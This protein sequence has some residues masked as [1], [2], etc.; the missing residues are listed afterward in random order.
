[1]SDTS[2]LSSSNAYYFRQLLWRKMK[3]RKFFVFKNKKKLQKQID[4]RKRKRKTFKKIK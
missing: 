2:S 1:M 3:E 4:L